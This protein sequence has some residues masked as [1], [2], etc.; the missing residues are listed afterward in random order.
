MPNE[1]NLG[2]VI[3]E[4]TR[5]L[6][7]RRFVYIKWVASGKLTPEVANFR[8]ACLKVAVD[9]LTLLYRKPQLDLLP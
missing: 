7:T 3:K 9:Q 8:C 6:Q 1:P 2:Q 4:L 5:E